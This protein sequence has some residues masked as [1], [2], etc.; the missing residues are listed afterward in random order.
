[1]VE[2]SSGSWS[3]RRLDRAPLVHG[4]VTFRHLIEGERQIEN[5]AGLFSI[6]F[7]ASP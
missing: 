5:L 6:S 3:Q 7:R 4:P 1:M 2:C